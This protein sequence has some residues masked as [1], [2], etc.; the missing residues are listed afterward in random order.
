[1]LEYSTSELVCW[2]APLLFPG[3]SWL[4]S[5]TSAMN[6]LISPERKSIS[7]I[8]RTIGFFGEYIKLLTRVYT[9]AVLKSME[10][11]ILHGK[12]KA[13]LFFLWQFW[14][15]RVP[16]LSQVTGVT[17]PMRQ[18]FVCVQA[19]WL[20]F[21]KIWIWSTVG[22]LLIVWQEKEGRAGKSYSTEGWDEPLILWQ[23]SQHRHLLNRLPL[24]WQ[25]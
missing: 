20:I 10:K 6:V 23:P 22:H 17:F 4:V 16:R 14:W 19:T 12:K 8:W 5:R 11:K 13:M 7:C 18:A 9:N 15:V 3:Q 25:Y 2:F 21:S 1:M 24:F